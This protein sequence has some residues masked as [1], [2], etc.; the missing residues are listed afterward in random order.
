MARMI[1]SLLS[2]EVK[3]N[4]ERKIFEWFKND[5]DSDGWIVLHS[6]GIANHRTLLYGEIDFI[7]IAPRYGVFALEVKG[8]RVKREDG[9]WHFTDKYGNTTTKKRGP[10]EQANEGVYSLFDT[11][12]KKT[13]ANS[14]MSE[15]LFGS[16]V[17]FPDIVFEE[18]DPDYEQ[19][20]VFDQNDGNN[21]CGFIKRLSKNTKRKWEE[22]YGHLSDDRIPDNKKA[23]EFADLLRGDFDKTVSLSTQINYAEDSLITLTN[24]QLKCLDQLEDNSRCLIQ[25]PAGTGKTL[26]AIEDVKKSV[27]KGEKVAIF[28]Y[29]S[30]LGNWLKSH[31]D[32]LPDGLQPDFAGTFHS[33]MYQTVKSAGLIDNIDADINQ[34]FFREE[35]PILTLE[36]IGN[37]I[38]LFDKIIIDEV[39]DL[40]NQDYL[41][42]WDEILK[43]GISRGKWNMYGDFTRQAIYDEENNGDKMKELLENQ[44]SFIKYKLR[45]NCRNTKPIGEEISG[46]TGFQSAEYLWTKTDG[47]PVNYYTFDND[48]DHVQKLE[49][50]IDTLIKGNIL[51]EKIT[52]L[53]PVK[54]ENSIVSLCTKY[55]IV[56][57]NNGI[58]NEISFST[59][60]A[61]KGLENSV[62]IITDVKSYENEKL[63]YVGFS[64]ARSALIIF[65][66]KSAGNERRKLFMRSI[67]NG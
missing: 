16:G 46:V 52:I 42:V 57:Y 60:Q 23:R 54:R 4:A 63:M 62:I 43:N 61:F 6:L 8:G 40:L 31:F 33:F 24:E 66:N 2:P 53:S 20:Q 26:L 48:D 36:A 44:T 22:K 28:C 18:N 5:P 14:I 19:W 55:N 21:V 47:P 34:E 56:E 15:L 7:V 25:G 45:I 51:P 64:R 11:V 41:A 35:L 27:V 67:K 50:I 9:V 49:G 13:S 17:M 1:P 39:Q 12:R 10:F 29:N 38:V 30:L 58:K 3:S 59:I 37:Q 32:G 65:E